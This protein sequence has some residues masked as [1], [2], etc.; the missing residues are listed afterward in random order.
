[1]RT[2]GRFGRPSSR[3]RYARHGRDRGVDRALWRS[4]DSGAQRHAA[5]SQAVG[6]KA[7]WVRRNEPDAWSRAAGWYNS[8]SFALK[9]LTGEYVLDHHT[10]SQCDP[11]YDLRAQEWY[12]PWYAD[13]MDGLAAPRLALAQRGGWSSHR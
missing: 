6:P 9:R 1:M 5:T 13:V 11:L 3:H 10:A 12:Q 4:R 8:N 2:I 7:L